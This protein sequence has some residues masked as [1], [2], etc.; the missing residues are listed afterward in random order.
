MKKVLI[1]DDDPEIRSLYRLIL[2]QEGLDVIE[3]R[4][5]QEALSLAQEEQPA[6]ILL[7]ILMPDIDGYEVCRRLRANPQTA[8][9]HILMFSAVGTGT[10]RRN[11][12]LV[13]ADDY[14]SKS[15]GPR[16]LVARIRSLLSG[17][18]SSNESAAAPA[19]SN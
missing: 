10:A 14:M 16:A 13:G 7:D 12:I 3:A 5:G 9:L 4:S 19:A 6:L 17:H 2:R 8:S 18:L 1:V 11:G 15:V